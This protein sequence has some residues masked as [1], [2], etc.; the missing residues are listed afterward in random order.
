[1]SLHQNCRFESAIGTV[2][3]KG[4]L[5]LSFDDGPDPVATPHILE[6]LGKHHAPATF[7]M[8]GEQAQRHPDL[9][10]QVRAHG[11]HLIGNHTWSHPNFHE[12][13]LPEQ[14]EEIQKAQAL[15]TPN[16]EGRW[17][18]YPYGNSTC[19]G[20]AL[21]HLL[22]YRIV[23]WHIDSCDWAFDRNGEVDAQEALECGVLP[24]YRSNYVEHVVSA[25]RAHNG[26]IVLMHE[27]HPNT[28]RQLDEVLTALESAG[29]V[30]VRLD[31]PAFE[32]DMR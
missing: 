31:E 22:D 3:P 24:Q 11:E 26:G 10:A 14:S 4:R 7:F 15:L 2:P 21:L 5:A 18:R 8:I 17:Y 29:F 1:E 28:V 19:D 20:N 25:A 30:F 32:A 13:S 6:V 23:G 12:I 9:V 27:I 16:P